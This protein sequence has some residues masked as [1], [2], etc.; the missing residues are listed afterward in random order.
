MLD[1]KKGYWNVPLAPTTQPK[2]PF[3]T[4]LGHWQY[5]VL[6][7]GLHRAPAKFNRHHTLTPLQLHHCLPQ[8]HCH[9]LIHLEDHI[10]HLGWVIEELRRISGADQGGALDDSGYT[11]LKKESTPWWTA[12][13]AEEPGTLPT[14]KQSC[15]IW[16]CWQSLSIYLQADT[17]EG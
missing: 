12:M 9:P 8:W 1:I 13:V 7:F 5:Q 17:H 2:I 15:G 4:A 6:P 3:H 16:N 11:G 10:Y 14:L